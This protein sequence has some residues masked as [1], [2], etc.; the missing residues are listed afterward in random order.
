[1]RRRGR[2]YGPNRTAIYVDDSLNK[3]LNR[4]VRAYNGSSAGRKVIRNAYRSGLEVF[5]QETGEEAAKLNLKKSGKGWR[6]LIKKRGSYGYK[7]QVLKATAKAWTGINYKKNKNLRISHLIDRGFKHISGK[8]VG[9]NWFR[10]KAF[11]K[12]RRKVFKTITDN[13]MWGMQQVSMTGKAPSASQMR[14]RHG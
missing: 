7:V 10:R 6:K 14:K 4:L 3:S 5:N 12:A 1:L 13:L 11:N 8:T 9:G 2:G